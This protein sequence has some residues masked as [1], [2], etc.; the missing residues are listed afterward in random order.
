M[1]PA[2]MVSPADQENQ[3]HPVC[4]ATSP[5]S[6]PPPMVD[7]ASARVALEEPLD[8]PATLA[9][10]ETEEPTETQEAPAAVADLEPMDNLETPDSP[11]LPA[12]LDSPE[13]LADLEAV[14]AAAT[15]DSLVETESLVDLETEETLAD[16]E[17]TADPDLKDPPEPTE[18]PDPPEPLV[19]QATQASPDAQDRT[20]NTVLAHGA[21]D[22][23]KLQARD[24]LSNSY[25]HHP[26]NNRSLFLILLSSIISLCFEFSKKSVA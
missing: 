19:S 12:N 4:P 24:F 10:L 5:R 17:R 9:P 2:R 18:T 21:L 13:S 7:A 8:N 6:K 14:E 3:A 15:L 1:P 23:S 26:N 25:R 22:S 20:A 16:L 11:E